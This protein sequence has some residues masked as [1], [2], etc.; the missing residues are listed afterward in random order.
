M[1]A[2]GRYRG[3][4]LGCLAL[5]AVPGALVV[6]LA[7]N[8]GGMFGS[9]TAFA[10]VLVLAVAAFA[11]AVA[12]RPLAGLA[13]RGLLAVGLM[14]ALAA[15]MLLSGSWSGAAGRA[16]VAFDRAL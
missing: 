12:P 9:T 15:L 16:A 3:S 1:P 7:F 10:A 6:Y 14:A 2:I 8:S 5:T 11:A 13:P 4:E